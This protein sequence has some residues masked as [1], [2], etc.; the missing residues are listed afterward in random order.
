VSRRNAVAVFL[1]MLLSS[2]SMA[3]EQ[4]AIPEDNLAYPVLILV[5]NG[6]TG[7][8]FFVN[9]G[10]DVYL[11][12]AKHVLFDEQTKKLPECGLDEKT[13]KP[14]ICGFEL[15]SYSKDPAEQARNVIGLDLSVLQNGGNV[16]GH[17][18]QDVAVVRLFSVFKPAVSPPPPGANQAPATSG[19][20]LPL[21][22]VT[23]ESSSKTGLLTVSLDTIKPFERVLVG[24]DVV[25]FG[26]PTS[27]GLEK[28]PQIDPTRPLLRKG[29]VAGSDPVKK[30]IVLDCPIYFGNSGGPVLELD[31]EA[32]LTHLQIIGVVT[33]YV[34]FVETAGSNTV[35]MSVLSNSGYSIATPMDFVLEL[36]R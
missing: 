36:I 23:V 10:K 22:G 7:S 33:Q 24:N 29:I 27:L 32:F 26:Y 14:L 2:G 4:R 13:Q 34:P 11:V 25:V 12:T 19:T 18:S 1:L 6:S 9:T 3:D 20:S 35:A 21:P 16:K 31:H 17:P 28:L 5:K 8:G 15:V 30:S